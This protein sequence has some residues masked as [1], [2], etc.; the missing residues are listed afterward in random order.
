MVQGSGARSPREDDQRAHETAGLVQGGHA[1]HVEEHRDPEPPGEDQ[2]V[3][4]ATT[5]HSDR[6][7][8]P[9]GMTPDDVQRRSDVARY[10]GASVFPAGRDALVQVA[11]DN[12]ATDEVVALLRGLPDGEFE[13]LQAVAQAAGIGTE[14]E[15][16]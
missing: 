10:L 15:R 5:G 2:P 6:Q 3:V 9:A 11:R 8:V 7:G 13:N 1:S 12:Q 16:S 14:Q 4:G